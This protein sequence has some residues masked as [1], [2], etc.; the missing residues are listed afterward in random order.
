M[1]RLV[2]AIAAIACVAAATNVFGQ[3]AMPFKLGTFDQNG[4]SFVGVVLK[5]AIVIDLAQASAALKT[6]AAKVA[7]PTDMKDLI[8]RYDTGVRARIGEISP[9]RSR[10]KER[11][12]RRMCTTLKSLKT[13]PPIMYPTTM[14]NVAVNYRAHAA[15][16]AG[17]A[18]QAG[19]RL[20]AM[21]C[22]ERRARL[23]SGSASRTTS[24]GIRTCSSSRR[25]L[26]LPTAKQSVCRS[27]APASTGSASLAWSS[28]A[29]P[30]MCPSIAP[31]TTSSDTRSRTTCRIA[32]DA[33]TRGTDPTG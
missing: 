30:T 29:R 20:R 22:P 1:T 2:K 24:G 6:P 10:S 3:S 5:D 27:A 8:A 14:L 12:A 31:A 17:G 19:G 21:R 7:A 33:A 26:S 25:R 13:L 15:E 9:T 4:R 28:A 18:P 32:G 16:M 11:A 23:E